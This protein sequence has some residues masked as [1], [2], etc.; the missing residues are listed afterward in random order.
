MRSIAV[1]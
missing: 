1:D